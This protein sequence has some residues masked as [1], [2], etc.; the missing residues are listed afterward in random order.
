MGYLDP[1]DRG[2]IKIQ[3]NVLTINYLDPDRDPGMYQCRATNSLR[4]KYSSGQLRVLGNT[5]ATLC[6]KFVRS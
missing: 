2:R 4:T 5:K 6:A 3:D 1:E